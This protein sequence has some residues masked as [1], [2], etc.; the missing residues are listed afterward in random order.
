PASCWNQ[1]VQDQGS[2]PKSAREMTKRVAFQQM[3]SRIRNERDVD[4]VILYKLSRMARNRLDD[5]IVAADLKKRGVTLVSA[6][7]AIDET[8]V[9]QLMHGILAAFNEFRSAEEGADIAYKMGEKAKKGGTLGR[10]PVGYLNTIDRTE[11][12]EIRAVTIDEE[13]APHVKHAFAMYA[14]GDATLEDIA[15]ELTDRGL[16]TRATQR[17]PAGPISVSKIHQMLQDRYYTGVVTYKGDEYDGRHEAIIDDELFEK[18]Q[19]LLASRG[20]AV[21]RRRVIHHYLKGS[22]WCGECFDRDG[23]YRRMIIRRT[24]SRSGEEYFYFFC[25]GT[26]DGLCNAKYSNMQRVEHAVTE[27]YKTLS[28]SSEFLSF[29]HATLD[30]ALADQQSAQRILRTQLTSQLESLDTKESNLLDLAGDGTLPQ[31]KIRAR[32]REISKERE[33]LG[34]HLGQVE[35]DLHEAVD[36]VKANLALLENPYELYLSASDEVRRRLNQ[37]LFAHILIHQDDI[38]GHEMEE[39]FGDLLTAQRTFNASRIGMPPEALHDLA[40]QTWNSYYPSKDKRAAHMGDSFT[41]LT[42]SALPNS[43]HRVLVCSKTQLVGL[44]GFEPATP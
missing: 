15:N 1:R 34:A 11:G 2:S 13:R 31:D 20:R 28:F 23:S 26:Q 4:Y 29:M 3:L 19:Q 32:L 9:G 37:A 44:T 10:A 12:R 36:F 17:R 7:E 6:T 42:L 21:E 22:L 27:H 43:D 35:Q 24:I 30:E 5:A 39:P 18:V 14:A 41:S 25:R 40:Q 16:R 8:P 38:T 33:R